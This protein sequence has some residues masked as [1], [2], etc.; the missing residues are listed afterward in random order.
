MAGVLI[1]EHSVKDLFEKL[2]SMDTR[3]SEILAQTKKTNGR[4]TKLETKSIGMWIHSHPFKFS[5]F[6]V[7]LVTMLISD[8]RHPVLKFV[9]GIFL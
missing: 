2:D 6:S 5:A 9:M 3:S 1:E 8:F 4:V 7:A